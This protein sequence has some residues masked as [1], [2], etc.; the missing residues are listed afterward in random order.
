MFWHG[1]AGGVHDDVASV[2]HLGGL[3]GSP[4]VRLLDFE[5]EICVCIVAVD[6][7]LAGAL[8]NSYTGDGGLAPTGA[9]C[10]GFLF[11][12]YHGRF[13]PSR[14]SICLLRRRFGPR[15]VLCLVSRLRFREGF[16]HVAG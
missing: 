14:S 13:L 4:D 10:K 1:T 7:E 6:L 11:G 16:F 9:P 12:R 8:G 5:W 2:A 3:Q 15:G